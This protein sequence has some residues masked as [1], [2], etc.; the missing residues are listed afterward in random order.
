MRWTR[1]T[2]YTTVDGAE[3]ELGNPVEDVDE[4]YNG[5][6]EGSDQE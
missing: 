3:D 5:E 2:I 1:V 4:L 6:W